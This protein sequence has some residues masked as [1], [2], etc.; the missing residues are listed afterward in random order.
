MGLVY[1]DIQLENPV[2]SDLQPLAAKALVDTGSLMLCVPEHVAIQLKL[3]QLETREV[4]LADGARQTVPYV[5]PVRIRFQNRSCFTGA[6][7]L[8]NQVLLGAIPIEDMDLVVQ[9]ALLRLS[10]N[11][12]SPNLPT[13]IVC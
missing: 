9:P 12:E 3:R 13:A 6:L 11:P 2:L 8:G 1:A 10:V 7:V 4:V 5:G